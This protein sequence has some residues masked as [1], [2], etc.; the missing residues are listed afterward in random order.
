[1]RFSFSVQVLATLVLA[2]VIVGCGDN[3]NDSKSVPT[4]EY[5]APPVSNEK[6]R[7]LKMPPAP[8]APQ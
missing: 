4:S 3:K 8:E 6:S 5:K 1:M 2:T 7:G